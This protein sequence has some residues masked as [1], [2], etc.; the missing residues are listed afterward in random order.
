MNNLSN[1]I[2]NSII[3]ISEKCKDSGLSENVVCEIEPQLESLSESL[4]IEKEI[5][6]IFFALIFAL[7]NQY[8]DSVNLHQ[9]AD[10]LDYPFLHILEY[11]KALDVLEEKS[12]IYMCSRNNAGNQS[13]N[14]GYKVMKSVS[15]CIID[16][17]PIVEVGAKE[18]SLEEV[19]CEVL[20]IGDCYREDY[21]DVTEYTRQIIAFEKKY[22]EIGLIKNIT[23]RFPD[24]IDSRILLYFYCYS[25][26]F[27]EPFCESNSRNSRR[28]PIACGFIP[29]PQRIGRRKAL[30]K[31]DDILLKE[32]YLEKFY[33]EDLNSMRDEFYVD[34]RLTK[35]GLNQF[36]GSS[37]DS[38]TVESEDLS[39]L[40]QTVNAIRDF[41]RIYE[42]SSGGVEKYRNLE[43]SETESIIKFEYFKKI[44]TLVPNA[45]DRWLYI[46]CVND[47]IV[48]Y[49]S[50]LTHTVKDLHGRSPKYFQTI[51][52]FIDEKHFLQEAG[53]LEIEKEEVVDKAKI[54]LTDKSIELL[55]GENADIYKVKKNSSNIMEPESLVEKALFYTEDMQDQI[56][57][58][59]Q[60]LEQ[61]NLDA[62]Q[63]RLESKGLSK[64]FAAIL[65]GAPGTGKTET[66]IQLAKRTNR[67]ILHVDISESKS[68]WFGES[69][70]LIKKI[71]TDY[72]S[73][74][75]SCKNRGENTPILLFNEA[76]ALIC[77]R[78]KLEGGGTRQTE[79]AM[80]NI[81]LEE[82]EKLDGIMIATTNL[83]ENMDAAFERRFLFKIKYSKPDVEV[84]SK[85]WMNKI[86][87]LSDED[88]CA[89]A[90]DF[91]FSGG[92]IDNIVRKSEI[93][94]IITGIRPA[95]GRLFELCQKERLEKTGSKVMGFAV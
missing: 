74:C 63:A 27:G 34:Y 36:F 90:K 69:E 25:V 12:L 21:M 42:N 78:N 58:L 11:R 9:I 85:I 29:N 75:K 5:E 70:K 20:N 71:F 64:G 88:A 93:D 89:L 80:Q 72:R 94:E 39:E 81:L 8:N 1:S 26:I 38:Y 62:I 57:M 45:F 46:D 15:N 35:K 30:T 33:T 60:S 95:Y 37:A 44:K 52:S 54:V 14:N 87:S 19:I 23:E 18:R 32:G 59:G 3:E 31:G 61:K 6:V 84:R 41:A 66:V 92:E 43:E 49:K 65:Y 10:F 82:M 91:D 40:D 53:L 83:S 67:K 28:G 77:K 51:R 17:T 22:K 56:E 55:Y 13:E 79:N 47:F 24:E 4:H 73:L 50:G 76:D 86:K 7:Q 48:G 16:G 2:L 68:M